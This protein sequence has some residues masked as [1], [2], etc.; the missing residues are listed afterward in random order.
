MVEILAVVAAQHETW[1]LAP[2]AHLIIRFGV[3]YYRLTAI[4]GHRGDFTTTSFEGA[5]RALRPFFP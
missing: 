5:L 2:E 1:L 4:H 3:C